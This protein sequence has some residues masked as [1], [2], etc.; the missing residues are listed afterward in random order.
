MKSISAKAKDNMQPLSSVFLQSLIYF[1]T[2]YSVFF[3]ILEALIFFY[4]GYGFY[5]PSSTLS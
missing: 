4:K 3:F 5:Y 2:L 1:N